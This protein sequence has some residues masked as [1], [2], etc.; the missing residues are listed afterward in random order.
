MP[1]SKSEQRS[2]LGGLVVVQIGE[3]K[4]K[5][6]ALEINILG[7]K[8]SKTLLEMKKDF[9]VFFWG[10]IQTHCHFPMSFLRQVHK[11]IF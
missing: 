8:H 10:N 4:E 5:T 9:Y 1:F 7:W 6:H 3:R 2:N 11:Y